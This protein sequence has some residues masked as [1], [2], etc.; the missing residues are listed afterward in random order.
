L[1]DSRTN[2]LLAISLFEGVY[3]HFIEPHAILLQQI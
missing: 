2:Q 1:D 3:H